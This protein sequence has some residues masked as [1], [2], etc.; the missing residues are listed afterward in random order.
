MAATTEGQQSPAKR[1]RLSSSNLASPTAADRPETR[2]F[3]PL[4]NLV[5]HKTRLPR[6]AILFN[7]T[8]TSLSQGK[9][10]AL[11]GNAHLPP[12]LPFLLPS[13]IFN[14]SSIRGVAIVRF[15]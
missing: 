2:K 4:S 14:S 8:P 11:W 5:I 13:Y 10:P 1:F 7:D 12:S 9:W 15:C 6:C 3:A